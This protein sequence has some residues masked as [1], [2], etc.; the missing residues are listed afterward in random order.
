MKTEL[1]L[2]LESFMNITFIGNEGKDRL[3]VYEEV[4]PYVEDWIGYNGAPHA[5]KLANHIRKILGLDPHEVEYEGLTV[6]EEVEIKKQ[7]KAT[8]KIE[9]NGLYKVSNTKCNKCG[10]NISWDGYNKDDPSPPIHVTMDGR[11]IGNGD[12]P[13][14][15]GGG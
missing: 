15:D 6:V 1:L 2:N 3:D 12:C 9:P 7:P 13:E 5:L 4:L 8:K 11:I 14:F 10:G